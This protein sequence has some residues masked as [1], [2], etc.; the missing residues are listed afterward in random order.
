MDALKKGVLFPLL[1]E[2]DQKVH[3][4]QPQGDLVRVGKAFWW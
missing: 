2:I 3:R 4:L 1:I